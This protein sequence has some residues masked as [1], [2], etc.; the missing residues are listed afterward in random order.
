[1][2][3]SVEN[4]RLFWNAC[5]NVR[6][7]GGLPAGPDQQLTR[8]HAFV[9]ADNLARLSPAGQTDLVA[10]G[11]RTIIDLR[12]EFELAIDPPPF[13]ANS[14]Q[15]GHPTYQNIPLL[16]ETDA[17]G[18]A[19][20][21]QLT[22]LAD[23][24]IFAAD[25]YQANIGQIITAM[26]AATEQGAILFHCHSGRD[27]T[28]IIAGLLLALAGVDHQLI[29]ADYAV[30]NRYLQP[31]FQKTL[32]EEPEIILSLLHHLENSYGSVRG[33]LR[34]CQVNDTDLSRLYQHLLPSAIL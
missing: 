16:D 17:E 1:M 8:S 29:A 34:S 20:G 14:G 18:I 33:Y 7:L 30:S 6:D 11:I 27:R 25:R 22:S 13:A 12:S 28:G 26:A 9:R 2:T 4:R 10:Y 19:Q 3:T 21:N 23:Y 24:Y 5:Y 31:A 32:V 15:P